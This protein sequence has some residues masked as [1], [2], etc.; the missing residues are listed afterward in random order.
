MIRRAALG[1]LLGLLVAGALSLRP[2]GAEEREIIVHLQLSEARE[3]LRIAAEGETTLTEGAE[4]VELG[5]SPAIELLHAPGAERMLV[6]AGGRLLASASDFVLRTAGTLRVAGMSEPVAGEGGLRFLLSGD[7]ILCVLRIGLTAYIEGVLLGEM[8]ANAP[9]EALKAQAV[10]SRTYVLRRIAEK[11]I[12]YPNHVGAT[13]L[14]QVF[15]PGKPP[16]RVRQAV[17]ETEG[18]IV[19][20]EGKPALTVYSACCGGITAS[21]A[22][23]FGGRP[24]PYL[25]SQADRADAEP[26]VGVR[27]TSLDRLAASACRESSEFRW[28]RE[29]DGGRLARLLGLPGKVDAFQVK[30]RD[31]GGR[32]REACVTAG[33]T[34]RSFEGTRLRSAMK[35]PSAFFG[36]ERTLDNRFVFRGAGSGH[37]AG[38][39]QS[40]AIGLAKAG[41]DHRRI[42]RFYYPGTASLRLY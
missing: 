32:V 22:E 40:G 23:A 27:F 20:W 7:R 37:G 42:L 18:E 19:A 4:R 31:P 29:F 11:G 21:S 24:V 5:D 36:V 28:H 9:L 1:T 14:H 6:F 38:L 3:R 30:G 17:D 33:A 13:T 41:F 15:R 35:L 26:G 10:A 12:A 39:C 16:A 25:V 34:V 8:G 2:A